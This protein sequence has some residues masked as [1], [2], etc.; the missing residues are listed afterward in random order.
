ME[1]LS[2][3]KLATLHWMSAMALSPALS[4]APVAIAKSRTCAGAC[5]RSNSEL[6]RERYPQ[7]AAYRRFA[8]DSDGDVARGR[9]AFNDARAACFRCH[10]VDGIRG[11][12]GT[13]PD[14]DRR[15]VPAPRADPAGPRALFQHPPGLQ[16]HDCEDQ[17]RADLGRGFAGAVS[18]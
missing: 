6:V 17:V 10:M 13:G 14:G 4:A 3:V 18:N 8:L 1:M 9:A 2:P 11:K 16:H 15:Q 5:S 7:P 12:A